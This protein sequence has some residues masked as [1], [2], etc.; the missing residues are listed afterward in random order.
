MST[1]TGMMRNKAHL[2]GGKQDKT[3]K[4]IRV[5]SYL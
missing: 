5:L 2:P 4:N 3:M 1:T